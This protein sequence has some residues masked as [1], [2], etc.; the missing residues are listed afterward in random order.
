[1][2]FGG[3]LFLLS[4]F[5]ALLRSSK[6]QFE[7]FIKIA[8]RQCFNCISVWK[9]IK[10]SR[11]GAAGCSL[12]HAEFEAARLFRIGRCLSA[13]GGRSSNRFWLF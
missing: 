1:M 5:V 9:A 11:A 10:V 12:P 7:H 2:T 13:E 3:F 8:F 6:V 4:R